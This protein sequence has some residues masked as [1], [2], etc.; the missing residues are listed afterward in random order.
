MASS[1]AQLVCLIPIT[2][3]DNVNNNN[4]MNQINFN[5]YSQMQSNL[6]CNNMNNNN[7]SQNNQFHCNQYN[8]PS[9]FTQSFNNSNVNDLDFTNNNQFGQQ[10]QLQLVTYPPQN[11]LCQQQP[12][13]PQLSHTSNNNNLLSQPQHISF[14]FDIPS[15]STQ[16]YQQQSQEYYDGDCNCY[17]LDGPPNNIW[18]NLYMLH[19]TYFI[20]ILPALLTRQTTSILYTI[21]K[22]QDV[23]ISLSLLWVIWQ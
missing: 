13:Q 4:N 10:T 12:Q 15:S 17:S 19:V 14:T 22:S 16:I 5:N 18:Y 9:S 11:Q 8:E 6:S 23:L 20:Y 21:L 7:N 1:S 3:L 2:P